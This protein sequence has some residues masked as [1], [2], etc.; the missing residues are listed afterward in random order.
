MNSLY[1][2][3]IL[4]HYKNPLNVGRLD[5]ATHHAFVQNPLCGDSIDLALHVDNGVI[6]DCAFIGHGCAISQAFM[7]LLS[8]KIKGLS[9]DTA[10]TISPETIH[11]LLGV[12]PSPAR[13][14]CASLC[15][16]A[17]YRA[18]NE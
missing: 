12:R 10:D 7:S 13:E 15:L 4:Y 2:E 8:E 1:R 9:V 17:V 11:E 16:D 3:N 18:L 14:K 5:N 6:K